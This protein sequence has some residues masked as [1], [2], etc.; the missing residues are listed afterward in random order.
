M[1]SNEKKNLKV[2][3]FNLLNLVLPNKKFYGKRSYTIEEYRKK[4][5]WIS[6][7][8]T[9]MDADIIGFQELFDEEALREVI[10]EHPLYK[11]AA[12]V[13][14]ARKGGSPAVAIVSRYPITSYTVYSDFP[15]QLEVEG[16]VVPFTEFSRPVLKAMVEL[17]SGINL[18]VFVAHLKSKRPLIP[19]NVDRHDPLE[20][21]KGEAR[22]LLLRASEANAL[23]AILLESLKNRTTPVIT[24]GDLNDT[25]TSVTTQII[26]G[27]APPRYW[28]F[29]QK[30][31]LWDILLYHVKDIQARQ[32]SKDVYY[33]HIHNGHYESLDHIMVSQELVKENPNRIGRVVYVRTFN[34][35]IV[36]QTFANKEINCWE[37]D[38]AQVVATIELDPVR[39][40]DSKNE[41]Y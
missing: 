34:D 31:K 33:T 12:V 2:A 1:N 24:L 7:Q 20:I 25:H 41:K 23:R 22:S 38:H 19:D 40:E 6:D 30:K 36:D 35:H 39:E 26:S 10:K 29:E 4:K 8:L 18:T 9:K 16:L 32:S 28:S 21:S 5:A 13:M 37:S 15:E 14:G 3:S 17:P 11:G 27:Q